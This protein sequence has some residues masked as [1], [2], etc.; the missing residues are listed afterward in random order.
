MPQRFTNS[1]TPTRPQVG[2]PCR[3]FVRS[4][5]GPQVVS[6]A[7]CILGGLESARRNLARLDSNRTPDRPT[8]FRPSAAETGAATSPE[9]HPMPPAA[10]EACC[11]PT[12]AATQPPSPSP[13]SPTG[14][15]LP[16]APGPEPSPSPR[17]WAGARPPPRES[18][19]YRRTAGRGPAAESRAGSSANR[20]ARWAT[21]Q[22]AQAVDSSQ[23][24]GN[25]P[26]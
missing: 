19:L 14:G 7:P 17:A 4:Q 22:V 18:G 15:R 9:R 26:V 13:S 16:A 2:H 6:G 24:E 12:H 20:V 25:L 23:F 8:T 1:E 11:P 5:G 21:S 3:R 10:T